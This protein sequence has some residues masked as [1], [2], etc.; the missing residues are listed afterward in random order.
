[1]PIRINL[2]AEVQAAE[3][4]RRQD[5]V[6]RAIIGAVV[7]VVL[8]L[9]YAGMLVYQGIQKKNDLVARQQ[10]WDGLRPKHEAIKRNDTLKVETDKNVEKVFA[11]ST[12]RWFWAPVLNALAQVSTNS[13]TTNIQVV[14]LHTEQVF[15]EAPEIKAGTNAVTK[16][17]I[18]YR[19]PGMIEINRIIITAKDF[20]RDTDANYNRLKIVL[21]EFP[22]IKAELEPGGSVKV[23]DWTRGAVD[24][25]Q[26]G[27]KGYMNF[28]LQ[29]Q[30]GEHF[31]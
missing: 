27:S 14:K 1:M 26:P 31:H 15:A 5:P 23:L 28:V 11:Y 9:G 12:N 20:G 22:F 2:L 7:L 21:A 6:K 8:V 24:P 30:F 19:P 10:V 16:A 18:K 4:L 29:C 3:E 17:L 25:M 13:F